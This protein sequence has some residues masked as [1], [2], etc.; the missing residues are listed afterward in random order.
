MYKSSGDYR[1]ITSISVRVQESLD[2]LS[3]QSNSSR[4]FFNGITCLTALACAMS[5]CV[6]ACMHVSVFASVLGRKPICECVWTYRVSA[7]MWCLYQVS[8]IWEVAGVH[9][10][11]SL[12][13]NHE[14]ISHRRR[15]LLERLTLYT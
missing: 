2:F 8:G 3:M 13:P 1:P 4:S 14:H 11:H 9:N 7:R 12:P 6:C 5:K 15:G 10:T